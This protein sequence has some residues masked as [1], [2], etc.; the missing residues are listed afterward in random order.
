MEE[1]FDGFLIFMGISI[2]ALGMF[3][4]IIDKDHSVPQ[5]FY[6]TSKVVCVEKD[7][8]T[9][10]IPQEKGEV[11]ITDRAFSFVDKEEGI[12]RLVPVEKCLVYYT[13]HENVKID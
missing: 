5:G 2:V 7:R 11:D 6:R 4:I 3:I 1:M 8:Q 13:I 12:Q 9:I 10:Y